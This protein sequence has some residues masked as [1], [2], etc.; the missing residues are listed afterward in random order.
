MSATSS[1]TLTLRLQF[2]DFLFGGEKGQLCIATGNASKSMFKQHWFSWPSQR[3]ELGHF[4]EEQAPKY[5]VW[6]GVTLFDRPE[7]KRDYAVAGTI[8]WSDL[9]FVVPFELEPIP[10]I[11]IESSPARY[12][13]IWQLKDAIP[14]DIAQDYSRKLAY[15]IG[16]DKSGWDLEQ[17]LRVPFTQNF[18]YEEP[19][20]VKLL[21][22]LGTHQDADYFN[23]LP[24]PIAPTNGSIVVEELPEELPEIE[25]VLYS[26]KREISDPTSSNGKVFKTLFE[27]EPHETDDWSGRLWRL[28][29]ICI[30]MG[31]TDEETFV[32]GVN[33][34]CNKYARDNRPID[35][36]WKEVQ[37]AKLKQAS[38]NASNT[39]HKLRMPQLVDPDEVDEDSFVAE[40]KEWA[41]IATD[42]PEQYHEVSCFIALSA[43]ISNGLNLK[44]P[45]DDNF[46]PNLWALVLGESTLSRKT[47][48]MRMATDLI[49]D[50][51]P[52]LILATDGS[53]E[54]LLSGLSGRPK[55]VSIFYKDEVS[56]FFDSINRKDY[57]AGFPET[58][59]QLYDVPKVLS[60]L[61]RKETITVTEP[62][63][64][65]FG[66]GIRD[67]V[68]NLIN[69]DYILSGF[70]PRFIIVSSE[71]DISRIRRT[72]PPTSISSSKKD[73]LVTRLADL[74]E[75]Y[76][77]QVPITIGTQKTYIDGVVEAHLTNE[78]WDF[79][80]DKEEQMQ[81]VA[82][83]SPWQTVA[84]PTLSRMAFTMLKMSML[85]AASRKPA[86]D[87]NTLEVDI[88]D[89]KQ[90][91]Y[92]IQKWGQYSLDLVT[93]A[94]KS[95]SEK[96]LDRTLEFIRSH[97]EGVTQSQ[98]MQRFHMSSKEMREV[99]DTL[100][101][102]GLAEI[103]KKGR[104]LL[105][106]AVEF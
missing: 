13:A 67:K 85:I 61:L 89:L 11:I 62:Y 15:H 68:Y 48:S 33:S 1:S 66:G 41:K 55:R 7:R 57:L 69:D 50:L 84:L 25:H 2:F 91:A 90:A 95:S 31:M 64:I 75:R 46:R 72:G 87:A 42:A 24:E 30:E 93:A 40:Y 23:A 92:Y 86:T 96:T 65:F 29:N 20:P 26:Y 5:N 74:K 94:G 36:M 81:L 63:F 8:I 3:M 10:S 49:T 103:T 99:R 28:L 6:F 70:L 27:T 18:K 17:L 106:K 54:G 60:R 19:A 16:A 39:T 34:K 21:R 22:I 101:D 105:I 97:T 32:V 44:L 37:K 38:F 43:C 12:Q 98:L 88:D 79:F 82:F 102:R 53:A 83:E 100:A 9:D 104:G 4:I 59:T 35:Y 80:G 45:Y 76:S 52:E 47:T 77:V 58:L 14:P 51:D 73:D 78:A 56:G 71:N